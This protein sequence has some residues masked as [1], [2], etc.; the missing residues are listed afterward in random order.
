MSCSRKKGRKS[1]SDVNANGR[2]IDSEQ[3]SKLST[4]KNDL[5]ETS[6]DD[7]DISGTD[8]RKK[9]S[10]SSPLQNLVT[11]K[12]SGR[13]SQQKR[14]RRIQV[15]LNK[16][17]G[18]PDDPHDLAHSNQRKNID[19]NES[20]IT[21]VDLVDST[22]KD[23]NFDDSDLLTPG[24]DV[25]TA[26]TP[27]SRKSQRTKRATKWTD[28][29][30]VEQADC[31]KSK[32]RRLSASEKMP[33]STL[34]TSDHQADVSAMSLPIVKRTRSFRRKKCGMLSDHE[35]SGASCQQEPRDNS[36]VVISG[37]GS[38]L[39]EEK[40]CEK[41]KHQTN[42]RRSKK[43]SDNEQLLPLDKSSMPNLKEN[44]KVW[45]QWSLK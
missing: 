14:Q 9:Q 44:S 12:G 15:D 2:V 20:K 1:K 28:D 21:D 26:S 13:K 16:N 3:Q 41:V 23:L 30:V 33:D 29:F 18:D 17:I 6:M 22:V 38:I 32:R 10:L 11:S 5:E 35:D 34:D 45:L 24:T 27:C 4:P 39:F 8:N 43:T 7:F 37:N 36:S 42:R 25:F 40:P 19:W 31:T